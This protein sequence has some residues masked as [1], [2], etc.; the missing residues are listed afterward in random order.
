[1]VLARPGLGSLEI[2]RVPD[3]PVQSI[4]NMQSA[5]KKTGFRHIPV[6]VHWLLADT[7][8]RSFPMMWYGQYNAILILSLLASIAVGAMN[9]SLMLPATV[10]MLVIVVRIS[11]TLINLMSN[12]FFGFPFIYDTKIQMIE[13]KQNRQTAAVDS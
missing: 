6:M 5:D 10:F 3:S 2:G 11:A 8:K 13:A 9:G 4:A 1:M 7:S 12:A